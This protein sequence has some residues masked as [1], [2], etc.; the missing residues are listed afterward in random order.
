VGLALALVAGAFYRRRHVAL[1]PALALAFAAASVVG[2]WR[3]EL[4][5]GWIATAVRP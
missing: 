2:A 1:G 4:V 3:P 5:G